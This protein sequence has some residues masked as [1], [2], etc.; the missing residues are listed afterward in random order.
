MLEEILEGTFEQR[1]TQLV[2]E[3]KKNPIWIHN[4]I[5][6]IS[7]KQSGLPC[8]GIT[9]LFQSVINAELFQADKETA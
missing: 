8:H 6:Q 2:R 3:G 4:V 5:L 9:G 7:K 1:A